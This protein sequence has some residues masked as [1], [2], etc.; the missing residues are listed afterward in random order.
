MLFQN[1]DY[2]GWSAGFGPGAYTISDIVAAGGVNDDASSLLISPG[3]TV[4]LYEDDN[5]SGSSLVLTED[6]PDLGS[7]GFNDMLSSMTIVKDTGT[8]IYQESD[9]VCTMEAENATVDQRSDDITWIP[10]SISD[11]TISPGYPR[12]D[13]PATSAAAI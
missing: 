4:T 2:G 7:Y 11:R 13:M 8:G 10:Q 1:Y 12:P 5:F 6:T 3:Y 9:G